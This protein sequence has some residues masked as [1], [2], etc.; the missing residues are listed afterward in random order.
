MRL[1]V[2]FA[3]LAQS[4]SVQS[5]VNT[6]REVSPSVT[7][8][9]RHSPD[10]DMSSAES[11]FGQYSGPP[12]G[13]F[14][15]S[16]FGEGKMRAWIQAKAAGRHHRRGPRA[17]V[18]ESAGQVPQILTGKECDPTSVLGILA[19]SLG[20]Y[21]AESKDSSSGG[22]CAVEISSHKML[23]VNR[24]LQGDGITPTNTSSSVD[25]IYDSFCSNSSYYTSYCSCTDFDRQANSIVVECLFPDVCY[26]Y[27]NY[28]C[29]TT[30]NVCESTTATY[31]FQGSGDSYSIVCRTF[32][33]PYSEKSCTTIRG[34][35]LFPGTSEAVPE[36]CIVEF[37][38]VVCN[39]CEIEPTYFGNY[40]L[41]CYVYDCTN[42][43]GN[44]TGNDC[45]NYGTP[46]F[47][48]LQT[49][50][51]AVDCNV[52]GE[53]FELAEP[54]GSFEVIS[55]V[56]QVEVIKCSSLSELGQ[57]DLL[58]IEN[59][60]K[61]S[62]LIFEPCGCLAI[63]TAPMPS[64]P[65]TAPPS[66]DTAPMPSVP[67]TSPPTAGAAGELDP[68]GDSTQTT[69]PSSDATTSAFFHRSLN[70]NGPRFASIVGL[71]V[72]GFALAV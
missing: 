27:S 57:S 1:A 20:Q 59:C 60:L 35:D 24:K 17:T 3:C 40:V 55:T 21:C 70:D 56:G 54:D 7:D 34:S 10:D 68:T 72:M 32:S 33:E 25:L 37:N 64:V 14:K 42:T 53:G 45:A 13:P 65:S 16:N 39:S 47:T 51:C 50:G 8:S 12:S 43:D 49:Y 69:P 52:C 6:D 11:W 62:E 23:D 63:D 29:N 28:S 9:R 19:C 66:A 26:D 5:L 18:K 48:Y 67:S 31:S 38:G 58:S 46:L 2:A 61:I 22:Y 44:F 71:L 36:E 15:T 4:L 41:Q 30:L